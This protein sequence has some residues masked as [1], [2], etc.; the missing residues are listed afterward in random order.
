MSTN[1]INF[2]NMT[3]FTSVPAAANEPTGGAFWITIL[4]MLFVVF[5]LINLANGFE[6]AL[7]VSSFLSLILG[8]LMAFQTPP[9][10]DWRYCMVFVALLI[11]SFL[12]IAWTAGSSTR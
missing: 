12:Y 2:T 11:F 10:I 7:I 3:D 1:L 8:V 5:F 9:L 4:F 6:V